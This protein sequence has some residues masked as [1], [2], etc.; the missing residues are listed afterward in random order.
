MRF[1]YDYDMV[2]LVACMRMP[3]NVSLKTNN[4]EIDLLTPQA[5]VV[6]PNLLLIIFQ[7]FK[8]MAQS[9]KT[10]IFNLT[11]CYLSWYETK[12]FNT[13]NIYFTI[14]FGLSGPFQ[15]GVV[16]LFFI[17]GAFYI[18]HSFLHFE[19]VNSTLNQIFCY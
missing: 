11:F 18:T 14:F 3:D 6:C 10:T 5:I 16:R 2:S 17:K 4:I 7:H 12:I 15:L 13:S 9:V 1:N 19:E 8:N